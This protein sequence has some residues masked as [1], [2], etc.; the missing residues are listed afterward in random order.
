MSRLLNLAIALD[1]L[2]NV[3]AGGHPDETLSARAWRMRAHTRAW[4]R[5]YRAINALFFWQADHCQAA[6]TSEWLRHHLPPEYRRP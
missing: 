2:V 4:R 1:Q 3:L 6:Y 5:A